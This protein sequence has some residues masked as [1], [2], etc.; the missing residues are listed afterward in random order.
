MKDLIKSLKVLMSDV[1]TFYFM[2]HG[3]HWN[4]E[5]PDFSQYHELFETIYSDAYSSI[6]PIAENIRKLDDYAPFS[7]QKF[8]DLRTIEFKDVQPNPKAMANSLLT[9]NDALLGVLKDTF[10]VSIKADEQGIANFL[11]E[12]IDMHQK[13]AWQLRASTK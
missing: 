12:R 13:W 3:Y 1:V 4:V 7:L 5:G 10:D 9:A 11:A 6:D 8:L 2:A